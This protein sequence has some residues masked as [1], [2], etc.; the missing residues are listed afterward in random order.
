[1][2]L[3]VFEGSNRMITPA[4]LLIDGVPV[5][6]IDE[7]GLV[8]N[9]EYTGEDFLADQRSMSIG[10]SNTGIEGSIDFAIMEPIWT[11]LRKM[12]DLPA[13]T[14]ISSPAAGDQYNAM[15]NRLR[16]GRL[17]EWW[18]LGP[19]DTVIYR[20]MYCE[21][22][23]KPSFPMA[24]R[25]KTTPQLQWKP[26]FWSTTYPFGVWRSYDAVAGALALS[27]STPADGATSV[28]VGTT[29]TLNFNK[30]MRDLA[31]HEDN[32]LFVESDGTTTVP[33]SA[34]FGTETLAGQTIRNPFQIILTPDSNLTSAD[35][36]DLTLYSSIP[37]VDGETL[38]ADE[39]V[40]FTTA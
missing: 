5:G 2:A 16:T 10:G 15:P 13:S 37:C 38:A 22:M 31:L 3:G 40:E 14:A 1:M 20:A 23:G 21:L 39:L 33:F 18:G 4:N 36:H 29:V 26:V 28:A 35:A 30:P 11:N 6:F 25:S 7:S 8:D 9:T 27:S 34:A 19:S 17:L 12:F 32:Y 24:S